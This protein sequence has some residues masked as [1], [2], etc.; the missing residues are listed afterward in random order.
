MSW[1]CGSNKRPVCL[2][3]LSCNLSVVLNPL[4]KNPERKIKLTWQ[5][6]YSYFHER[7]GAASS[8]HSGLAFV[9]RKIITQVISRLKERE[10]CW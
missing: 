2:S 5:Y 7:I 6:N 3:E 1:E 8:I 4:H 9:E 10:K